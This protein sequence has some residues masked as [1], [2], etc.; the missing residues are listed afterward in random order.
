LIRG[1]ENV[2]GSDDVGLAESEPGPELMFKPV[3]LG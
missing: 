3:M 2:P 1:V